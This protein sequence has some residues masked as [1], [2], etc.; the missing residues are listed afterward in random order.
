MMAAARPLLTLPALAP[1][2]SLLITAT[3]L[4]NTV[5]TQP[6]HQNTAGR[7]F[8]GFLMCAKARTALSRSAEWGT[9][10]DNHR[11]RRAR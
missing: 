5:M 6:Q 9:A 8:G 11:A 1:P 3:R 4:T 10:V 7:V 2:D